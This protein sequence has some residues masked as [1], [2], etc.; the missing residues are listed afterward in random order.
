M[1]DSDEVVKGTSR[2]MRDYKTSHSTTHG[3]LMVILQTKKGLQ[4]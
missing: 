2:V 1:L 4:N 3:C